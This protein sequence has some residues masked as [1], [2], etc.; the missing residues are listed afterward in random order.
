MI[1]S[2]LPFLFKLRPYNLLDWWPC[3]FSVSEYQDKVQK[4]CCL[5]G[6][7]NIPVSY[8]CERRSK[9]ILDGPACVVAFLHCCKEINQLQLQRKE[10]VLL[11]ARSKRFIKWTGHSCTWFIAVH[12][13]M[14]PHKEKKMWQFLQVMMKATWLRDMKYILAPTFLRA[15]CGLM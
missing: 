4:E 6:M 2:M 7:R 10:D 1:L 11:L 9:Y 15:G 8:T 3:S 5:D 13:K 12:T 14:N